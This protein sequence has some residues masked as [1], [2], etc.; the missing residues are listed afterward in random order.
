VVLFAFV[1]LRRSADAFIMPARSS[2][3]IA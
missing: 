1:Q 2:E 3:E